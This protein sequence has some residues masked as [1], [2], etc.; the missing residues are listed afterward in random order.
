VY[1]PRQDESRRAVIGVAFFPRGGSAHVI[2][3]LAGALPRLGWQT[4][5]VS[6]TQP[7]A[8]DAE[9]F[10]AGLDVRAVPVAERG[11]L[12]SYEDREDAPDRVFA[13]LGAE[14]YERQVAAWAE[15]LEQ[16]GAAQADVLHLHHLT[17]L[18]EAAA[19]V[20]PQVPVVGHL[21]G[22]EL[23]MLERIAAGAPP[24]WRHAAAWAE[25]MRAWAARC[26]LT[27]VLTE[28]QKARVTRLLGVPPERCVAVP[29][30]VD[31]EQFAPAP[32]DRRAHWRRLLVERPRGWRPGGHEGSVA[33]RDDQLAAFD[34][35][36][37]VLLYVG[38]FTEVKRVG[39]LIR[40]FARAQRDWNVRVPLVVVGGHPGEW[41]GE[42]PW[43]AIAASGARDVFLAGWQH[44]HELPETFNAA[45]ALVLPSVRE[46]FGSVLVEAMACGLPVVAAD[47]LGPAEIVRPGETGWLVPPD[48]EE[49][50]A[51]VLTEVV[52]KPAERRRSGAQA[53]LDAVARYGRDAAAGRVAA[54]YVAAVSADAAPSGAPA[55]ASS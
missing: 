54:T 18:H 2:R 15:A 16:A 4:T 26:T 39:L 6:G 11:L 32:V 5:V 50:L 49:A 28:R 21:H 17:P 25:R 51:R 8:G 29:N 52:E 20:A 34:G 53:R 31:A 43:E 40:A 35:D 41:E 1:A 48:D 3:A 13:D 14:A 19:R 24:S 7:G 45:D 44:H 12:A 42:H 46:Q 37:P 27:I 30:G 22:T 10:Y 36:G 47:A 38:R 23:L 55:V 33:Y 9:Q